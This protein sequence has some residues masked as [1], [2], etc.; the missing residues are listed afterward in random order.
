MLPKF[1]L[2]LLRNDNWSDFDAGKGLTRSQK[3]A[4]RSLMLRDLDNIF[5]ELNDVKKRNTLSIAAQSILPPGMRN[6]ANLDKSVVSAIKTRADYFILSIIPIEFLATL[7][8]FGVDPES[9]PNL[10]HAGNKFYRAIVITN[11]GREVQVWIGNVGEPRN[12]YCAAYM[13]SICANVFEFEKTIL[14]G[15]AG[16]NKMNVNLGDVVGADTVLD[17][18]GGK[19]TQPSPWDKLFG[20]P[21]RT[22]LRTAV[23]RCE[24]ELATWL[25]SS[26]F[27]NE[28]LNREAV[29]VIRKFSSAKLKF[30]DLTSAN[31]TMGW[32]QAGEKVV[33]D[34]SLPKNSRE[35]HDKLNAV[36][37][38]GMGF[39]IICK[40]LELSWLIFRGI[41]DFGDRRKGD[42]VQANAALMAALY[43]KKFIYDFEGSKKG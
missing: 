3:D 26:S 43:A 17:L 40:A 16:G 22:Q 21:G 27:D 6:F 11:D 31:F 39:S 8:A 10:T 28:D 25:R 34:G 37:M 42:S 41:S 14:V 24:N 5:L 12:V 35:H 18:E 2:D 15:I 4:L 30:A 23:I 19:T 29:D 7:A 13:A 20:R 32:V 33:R 1:L 38:E 9:T 36:E